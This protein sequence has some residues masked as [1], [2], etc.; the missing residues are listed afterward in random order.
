MKEDIEKIFEKVLHVK[1]ENPTLKNGRKASKEL[2]LFQ[3][4]TN[5][6]I[7]LIFV[8]LLT[9]ILTYC[10]FWSGCSEDGIVNIS[11]RKLF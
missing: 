10:K 4:I 5:S 8:Y 6:W 3:V 11:K 9:F 1:E 7:Q 2:K